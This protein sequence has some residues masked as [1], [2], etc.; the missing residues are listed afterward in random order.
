MAHESN[1]MNKQTEGAMNEMAEYY[2]SSDHASEWHHL[3]DAYKEGFR[4]CHDHRQKEVDLLRE[5]VE[6]IR[7]LPNHSNGEHC[8]HEIDKHYSCNLCTMSI[9]KQA[10]KVWEGG[11]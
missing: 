6:L 10:L 9:L 11:T 2:A 3:D 8:K 1:Q 4:A 5:I 7:S